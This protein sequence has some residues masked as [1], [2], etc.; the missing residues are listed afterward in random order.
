MEE[1]DRHH[2]VASLCVLLLAGWR[3]ARSRRCPPGPPPQMGGDAR[4]PDRRRPRVPL[5]LRDAGAPSGQ[6][7]PPF[8]RGTDPPPSVLGNRIAGTHGGTSARIAWRCSPRAPFS[9]GS[10]HPKANRLHTGSPGYAGDFALTKDLTLDSWTPNRLLL[11]GRPGA[12]VAINVN[13]SSYWLLNGQRLFP[14]YRQIEPGF[15]LFE[16][17][18]SRERPGGAG[19]APRA[20]P[21]S[22]SPCRRPSPSRPW[23]SIAGSPDGLARNGGRF[24]IRPL[25]SDAGA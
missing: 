20:L 7:A 8:E 3:C 5:R 4:P 25:L 16:V 21:R 9:A 23:P 14:S 2:P 6:K 19:P 24:W 18:R 22:C 11:H 10:F 15:R 1:H 17:H 12:K 13:P